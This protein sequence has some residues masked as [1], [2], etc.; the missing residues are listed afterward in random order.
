[1]ISN[2]LFVIY[3]K[4]HKVI[5]TAHNR[6]MGGSAG[7]ATWKIISSS[8]K[9]TRNTSGIALTSLASNQ[10]SITI[11]TINKIQ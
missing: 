5:P 10:C 1:M 9:S 8:A 11:S 2:L 7:F 3:N 4:C 6:A